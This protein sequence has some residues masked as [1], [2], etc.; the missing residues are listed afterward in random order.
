MS[1]LRIAKCLIM[2]PD[3]SQDNKITL[4]LKS[5]PYGAANSCFPNPFRYF[6]LF[7]PERGMTS[8]N[9]QESNCFVGERPVFRLELLVSPL[10]AEGASKT[11]RLA[12]RM[13]I[14]KKLV[15]RFKLFYSSLINIGLRLALIGLP[16]RGPKKSLT[17]VNQFLG[18][19][20]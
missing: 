13:Q 12:R 9:C 6:N 11:H 18:D 3:V 14:F 4:H 5:H 8:V 19:K 7:Y 17:F 20:N 1:R 15:R 2:L 10:E 16:L